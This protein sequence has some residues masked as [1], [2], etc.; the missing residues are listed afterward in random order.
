MDRND[1]A[2]IRRAEGHAPFALSA[3]LKHGHEQR[4]AG[5]QSFAGADQ[6]AEEAAAL[7]GA[8]TENGFHFDAVV[9]VHHAAGF[10]DR[11]FHRVQFDLDELHVI[12]IN[13][14]INFVHRCHNRN[15]LFLMLNLRP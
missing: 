15:W 5:D 8:V 13:L 3:I 4:F 14:E 1:L 9:H 10:G 6:R 7:L 12:A 2:G 11:C